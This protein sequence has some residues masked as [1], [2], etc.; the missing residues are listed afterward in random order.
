MKITPNTALIIVDVQND[1][2]PG[3]PLAAAHGDAVVPVLNRYIR[4]FMA[5]RA[6]V[7]LTRDWHPAGHCSFKDEGG[8][9]PVHCVQNTP[10]AAFHP[11]LSVPESAHI[12]SKGT[13]IKVESY[14][15][16][17]NTDLTQWLRK[18]KVENLWIGGL[19]T[20]YCV[21]STVLD[22]LDDGFQVIVLEDAV[23]GVDV[24]PGDSDKAF[25]EMRGRGAG[26]MTLRM[27]EE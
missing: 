5:A 10:G 6:P 26:G 1:F 11:G 17:Q 7:V 4:E 16:F 12:V 8:P 27:A 14:S 20:D 21:R 23:R 22:A 9:W 13:N 15:G 25:E 24:R 19:A 18:Q 2:C 3:G